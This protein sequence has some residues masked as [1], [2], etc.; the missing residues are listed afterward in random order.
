M[1]G[2]FSLFMLFI[3]IICL[4][5]MMVLDVVS[6]TAGRYDRIALS[7][8]FGGFSGVFFKASMVAGV[9]GGVLLFIHMACAMVKIIV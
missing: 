3:C 5:M 1:F 7:D 8:F 4:L 6:A 2:A 9:I